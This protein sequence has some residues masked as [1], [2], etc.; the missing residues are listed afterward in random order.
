MSSL[1]LTSLHFQLREVFQDIDGPLCWPVVCYWKHIRQSRNDKKWTVYIPTQWLLCTLNSTHSPSH[2][3]CTEAVLKL[4]NNG[5]AGK[6]SWWMGRECVL[7]FL[8]AAHEQCLK[9]DKGACRC[10]AGNFLTQPPHPL[11]FS[12][13]VLCVEKIKLITV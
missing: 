2:R 4:K 5:G 6:G 3:W 1:L 13:V 8:A 11:G 12:I 10:W 9:G 7:V